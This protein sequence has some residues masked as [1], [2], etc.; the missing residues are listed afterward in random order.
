VAAELPDGTMETPAANGSLATAHLQH[1]STTSLSSD[2]MS[3]QLIPSGAAGSS[4]DGDNAPARD[5][6]QRPAS[7]SRAGALLPGVS[8]EEVVQDSPYLD[9]SSPMTAYE[10]FKAVALAPYALARFLLSISGLVLVWAVTR[11]GLR[12]CVNPLQLRVETPHRRTRC[13]AFHDSA[14]SRSI[15]CAALTCWRPQLRL[16]CTRAL[17]LLVIGAK[18][19]E[20]CSP[21]RLQ[22]LR[23]WLRFWT[24]L[25]LQLGLSFWDVRV[26]G[27]EHYREA[28]EARCTGLTLCLPFGQRHGSTGGALQAHDIMHAP[29]RLASRACRSIAWHII[30][31]SRMAMLGF[32]AG[33]S[34]SSTMCLMWTPSC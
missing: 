23:P 2:G 27:W 20:P 16:T 10:W 3:R 18:P 34:A 25:F 28:Q 32:R 9:L 24:G 4:T 31:S 13:I 33:P 5:D 26:K 8:L 29:C 6:T 1:G 12:S 19:N 30:S 17:Q 21:W 15:C 14:C 11:V 22:L 7:V